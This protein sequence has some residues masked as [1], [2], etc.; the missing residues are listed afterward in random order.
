M[1][2]YQNCHKIDTLVVSELE[3]TTNYKLSMRRRMLE[4]RDLSLR[5]MRTLR[6]FPMTY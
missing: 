2:T 1:I 3:V 5:T 4:P 6:I